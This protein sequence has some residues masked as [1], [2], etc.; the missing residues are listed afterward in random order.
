M[1]VVNVAPGYVRTKIHRGMGVTFEE[2]R[3]ALGDPDFMT[4][5]E[6][7]DMSYYCYQLPAHPCVRELVVAPTR[8]TF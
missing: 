2:C 3:R 4:A 5:E 1:R 7:A 6:P 8:S